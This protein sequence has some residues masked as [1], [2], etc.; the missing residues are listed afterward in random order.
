MMNAEMPAYG[1]SACGVGLGGQHERVAVA[2]VGDPHFR[3]VDH[4]S[5]RRRGVAVVRS[6]CTSVPASDFRKGQSAAPLAAGQAGQKRSLL[7]FGAK[8]MDDV[9]DDRMRAQRPDDAHPAARQLFDDHGK[10]GVVEPQSAV[11]GRDVGAKQA[12]LLEPLD[13]LARDTRRCVPTG[14]PR[15]GLRARRTCRMPATMSCRILCGADITRLSE[16]MD[17]PCG[18]PAGAERRRR[19]LVR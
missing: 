8:A 5:H 19:L 13:D 15:A 18:E 14:W 16:K 1:G 11:L 2:A 12:E 7:L 4:D 3:A 17:A 6:R 10:R 9:A